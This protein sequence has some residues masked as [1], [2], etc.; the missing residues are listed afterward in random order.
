MP[1]RKRLF[2]SFLSITVLSV[3]MGSFLVYQLYFIRDKVVVG[4]DQSAKIMSVS[5]SGD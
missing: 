2:L 5:R 4:V 1:I 3:I